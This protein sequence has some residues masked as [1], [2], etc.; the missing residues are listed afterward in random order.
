MCLCIYVEH[1][2]VIAHL[3]RDWSSSGI[4]SRNEL[5]TPILSTMQLEVQSENTKSV[6]V[7]GAGAGRLAYELAQIGFNVHAN[8]GTLYC[9]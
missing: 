9:L 6:L 7:P 2:K 8:D 5:Y 4:E 3:E 1:K